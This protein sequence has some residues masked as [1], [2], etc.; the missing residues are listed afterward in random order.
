M[1]RADAH[2]ATFRFY[3][4]LNDLLP[5][6]WRQRTIPYRF[7][8]SPSVKDA[9]EALGVPHTEV[10]LVVRDGEPVTFAHRLA[11]GERIAVYPAFGTL[12]PSDESEARLRPPLPR[13]VRFVADVH[14]G[15]LARS[16]RLLGFDT[17]FDPSRGADEELAEIAAREDRVLLT[18]DRGLLRRR[19]VTYGRFV[20]SD[21]PL[22]QAIDVVRHF[23]LVDEAVTF[24]RCLACNAVPEPVA[25]RDIE[26]RL[27]P[28]TRRAFHE[29]RRC[30]GC[31][32]VY[33]RGSHHDRLVAVID[34]I[35]FGASRPPAPGE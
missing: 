34:D 15:T 19:I 32:R 24:G 7:P 17:R 6:G 20:R 25:K 1:S 22:D 30:P 27:E 9:I 23:D 12:A 28:G 14:L 16:L 13:P 29:F 10:A 33:W 26:D 5:A 31:E 8:A 3:G 35:R 18:R 21:V 4:E 11:D 2:R